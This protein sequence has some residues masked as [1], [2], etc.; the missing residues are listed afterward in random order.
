MNPATLLKGAVD[1]HV[2]CTP[3]VVPRSQDVF[4]LA[5]SARQA[6]MAGLLL[7][8]HTTSTVGRV[9]ALNRFFDGAPR[10]F[11]SIALNP[12]L[13]G[14]NPAAVES[15]IRAG[16]DVIYFPTYGASHH[17][18]VWGA[19]KPPTAFPLPERYEPEKIAAANAAELK[20]GCDEI[21][22]MIAAHGKVLATG[23]VSPAESMT[24]LK[25]AKE[26]GVRRMVVTHASESVTAMPPELQL[27]AVRMGAVI[28]HC[29]F[30]ATP[31]CPDPVRL[32]EIR[33]QVR[34]VGVEHVILS[35]D[36]G[37]VGN[38]A[39]VEGFGHYLEKMSRL[40]F[41][42]EEIRIMSTVNPLRL[43]TGQSRL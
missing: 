5:R 34:H 36:F 28:E 9:Y 30:A 33:D 24:L 37:Q 29:F 7:K 17:I 26:A 3:D 14:I 25:R 27:E 41:S 6:G 18:A 16:V 42:A 8:E 13:G 43:L 35:S 2:H 1:I 15:A 20:P 23:H 4:D 12:P 10:F 39:P 31:L 21:L 40:G 22:R 11:S 38:P 32:E 19:G